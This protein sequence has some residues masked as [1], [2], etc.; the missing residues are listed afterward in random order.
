[1]RVKVCETCRFWEKPDFARKMGFCHRYP[2]SVVYDGR[3]FYPDVHPN[4]W[5]G[6]WAYNEAEDNG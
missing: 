5:C 1:M 3:E 6:E 4:D 2:R